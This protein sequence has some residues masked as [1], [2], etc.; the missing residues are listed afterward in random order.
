MRDVLKNLAVLG[1]IAA[2]PACAADNGRYPSLALRPFETGAAPVSPAP[3]NPSPIRP[4]ISP[5]ALAALRSKAQSAHAAF[6]TQ[7]SAAAPLA[8]AA[9]GQSIETNARAAA[10]T[11]LAELTS[12]RGATSAVLADLDLLSVEAATALAADP[13]LSATQ[14]E[15]A[16]LLA[17]EDAGIARLWEAMGS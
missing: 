15:V 1:L 4:A 8:R 7:E 13:A 17:R 5:E 14:T 6:L 11:A 2:L 16:A 10:L 12:R 3:D 9:A